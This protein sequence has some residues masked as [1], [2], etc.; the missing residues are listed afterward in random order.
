M[1]MDSHFCSLIIEQL[2]MIKGVLVLH[3]QAS[4]KTLEFGEVFD[5]NKALVKLF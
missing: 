2:H 1:K 4:G 5:H 3:F